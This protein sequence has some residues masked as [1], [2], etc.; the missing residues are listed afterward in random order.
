MRKLLLII[1]ALLI[2]I[3]SSAQ[4]NARKSSVRRQARTTTS[5]KAD[6]SPIVLATPI[7]PANQKD[8]INLTVPKMDVV[9]V[10]FVGLGMRGPGAVERWANIDG[11]D[12]KALCDLDADR[13]EKSQKILERNGRHRADAYSGSADAYKKM[14]ERNDI[15]IIYIATDWIHH[16]PIALYAMEHGKNV[17]IEVPAAMTINDIWALINTSERTRKHCMMLENCVYD[18]FEVSALNMARQGVFGEVLHVEGSYLHNLDDFWGEYKNNWRLDFNHK[19]RGDVYPT[20]GIGPDCQVLGIHRTDLMDYLVAM[21]TKAVNG[22]KAVERQTG[23]PCTDFQNGDQTSTLI[24]TIKGKT[25]LI[26]HDVMTPRPYSR[27]FQIVGTDGYA[28]KYPVEQILLRKEQAKG[29]KVDY[30]NLNSHT[31]LNDETRNAMLNDYTPNYVKQI[32]DKAKTVG[33]HGGMDYIMDYRLVYCLRNGLP[34]DMD[35]YDMAEWC[36]IGELSRI[37]IENGSAPV[38][39]PDFT[40]GAWKR[41]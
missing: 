19:N 12:I 40:R 18:F 14:C 24:R 2:T 25:M 39:V 5:A 27:M 21:D 30:Q 10:G 31:P 23:K 15:D 6:K 20:H 34:L 17:A 16:V 41:R 38:K 13:V 7:R 35:V 4:Q 26:Q 3:S 29:L 32:Q 33:G 37:S 28:S 9:R 11:T 22:P 8:V 36:C 1:S